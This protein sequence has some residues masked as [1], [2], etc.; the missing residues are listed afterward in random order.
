MSGELLREKGFL[1]GVSLV[2]LALAAG[3]IYRSKRDKAGAGRSEAV[4]L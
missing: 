3:M 4:D 1:A 2:S